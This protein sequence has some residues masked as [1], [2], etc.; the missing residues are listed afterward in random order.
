MNPTQFPTLMT[1]MDKMSTFTLIQRRANERL[2]EREVNLPVYLFWW[3][4]WDYIQLLYMDSGRKVNLYLS[5]PLSLWSRACLTHPQARADFWLHGYS[6][7]V[8]DP[9][10]CNEVIRAAGH[11][12]MYSLKRHLSHGERQKLHCHNTTHHSAHTQTVLCMSDFSRHMHEQIGWRSLEIKGNHCEWQDRNV[13]AAC[14]V[15]IRLNA[16]LPWRLSI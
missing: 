15:Y 12:L 10:V 11:H 13:T 2:R 8:N 9:C 1:Y 14:S 16:Q 6:S 5:L 7:T 3:A 4:I